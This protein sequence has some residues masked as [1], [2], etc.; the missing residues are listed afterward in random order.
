MAEKV[1][2]KG[3]KLPIILV[4]VLVVAGGGFFMMG[5]KEA[6]K[7]EKDPLPK[8][9][10]VQKLGDEFLVNLKGG[11][12]Y[13]IAEISVQVEEG[14]HATDP[15]EAA[16]GEGHGA[17]DPTFS[18]ARDAINM[19]LANKTLED[20]TKKD[21]MKLLKRDLA[22]AMNHALHAAHPTEKGKEEKVDPKE[23]HKKKKEKE[24]GKADEHHDEAID[25]E[26]LDEIGRDAEEGPVL[27]VF[28]DKFM[29]SKA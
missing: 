18:V 22:L 15:A 6:P 7:V 17:G 13:L 2:K 21:G 4:A 3:G 26:W 14:G 19:V 12:T 27:K 1:K 23:E 24:E 10:A 5:K 9:G 16:G 28:F 20:I 8:L 11:G 29:Y 25:H